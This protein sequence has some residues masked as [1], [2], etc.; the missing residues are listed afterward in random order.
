M[1]YNNFIYSFGD[2][3]F[4]YYVCPRSSKDIFTILPIINENGTEVG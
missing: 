3:I 4:F 2:V 1:P